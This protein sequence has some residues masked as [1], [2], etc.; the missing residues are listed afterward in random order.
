MVSVVTADELVFAWTSAQTVVLACELDCGFDGFG[1][2][3]IGLYELQRSRC[4]APERF[5]EVKSHAGRAMHGR[6]EAEH[7]HLTMHRVNDSGMLM[8]KGRHEDAAN[9]VK[10]AFPLRIP[11]VEAFRLLDHEGGYRGTLLSTGNRQMSSSEGFSWRSSSFTVCSL[12][13]ETR[14]LAQAAM[15]SALVVVTSTSTPL[16]PSRISQT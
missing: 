4:H 1:P 5:D 2:T 16:T 8:P 14:L 10:V 3:T 9:S 7:F 13:E 6:G 12:T 15:P 11:V